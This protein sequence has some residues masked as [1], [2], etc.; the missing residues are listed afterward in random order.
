M[1]GSNQEVEEGLK[2]GRFIKAETIPE[3]AQKT[4]IPADVLVETVNKYI[5]YHKGR[6]GP[7]VQQAH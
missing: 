2:R 4:G 6:Q 1:G 3:L 7:R 5:Q